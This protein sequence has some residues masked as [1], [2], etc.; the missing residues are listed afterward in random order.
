MPPS[1]RLYEQT[2]NRDEELILAHLGMV[3]RVA[4]HLKARIPPFM[5]VDELVQVGM[6]GL[7]EAA[8]AFDPTKGVAFESYAHSR[9]RG[10][11]IDEVRRLS[12]LPRSAVAFNKSHSSANQALA[13]ELGRAPTQAELAEFMGRELESFEKDRGSARQ[14]ETY[15][16]EV[17]SEEVMNIREQE[18]RQ[19]D[20]LVEESQMMNA[21]TEAIDGLPERDKLVIS[22]YYVEELNLREIGEVL[23]V[24]ESRVSQILSA[25][26]KKLRTQ[27][28]H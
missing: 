14:F 27:L 9:V 20:A 2:Q 4:V 7:I 25:N 17:V 1:T 8:R 23:G 15:S 28:Q 5:E 16:M 19:P 26:V 18:S 6:I 11:M 24:S 10:A 21:L 12:F 13:T 3:K 22:L